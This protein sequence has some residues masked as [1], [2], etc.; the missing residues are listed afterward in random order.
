MVLISGSCSN[1]KG[2]RFQLDRLADA[3]LFYFS[4]PRY[5]A[6][7]QKWQSAAP[8]LSTRRQHL[9]SL[10]GFQKAALPFTETN[11]LSK[12]KCYD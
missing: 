10:S 3:T 11:H 12:C 1:K 4:H 2:G 9:G 7:K 6:G 8:L 5:S